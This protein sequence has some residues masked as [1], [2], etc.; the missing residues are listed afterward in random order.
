[1]LLRWIRK[2]RLLI[3]MFLHLILFVCFLVMIFIY[4]GFLKIFTYLFI[5]LYW[6]LAE[7]HE[8]FCCRARA[9]HLWHALKSLHF[10]G[11]VA[12]W[13]VGS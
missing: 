12:L 1:M 8:I 6:V 5:W 7:T 9:L 4:F 11:L 13:R 10:V 3:R 2:L